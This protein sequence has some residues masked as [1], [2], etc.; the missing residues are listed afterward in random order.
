MTGTRMTSRIPVLCAAIAAYRAYRRWG[1]RGAWVLLELLAEG[2][3]LLVIYFGA[4]LAFSVL[5]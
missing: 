4:L 1:V 3:G 5:F 2:L